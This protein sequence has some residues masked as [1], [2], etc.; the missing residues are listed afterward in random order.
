MNIPADIEVKFEFNNQRKYYVNDFYNLFLKG[1]KRI[2]R[3]IS[4]NQG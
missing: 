1:Q 3:R 4:K 2:S